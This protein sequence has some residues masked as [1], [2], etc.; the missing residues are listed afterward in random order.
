MR[1]LVLLL[2]FVSFILSSPAQAGEA[3]FSASSP[4]HRVAVLELYTSQ[5]CSSCPPAERWLSRLKKTG[6]SSEQ[7][8]PLAFHV[9]YWDYI[10][11]KDRFGSERYDNRQREIARFNRQKT[12]YTP[13]FVLGGSDYRTYNR[14]SSDVSHIV[15]MPSSID[16]KITA[17]KQGQTD[18]GVEVSADISKSKLKDVV[19]FLALYENNLKSHIG[20]GENEGELLHHDYVVRQ[21]YGPFLKN[22]K[23][24]ENHPSAAVHQ[25][26]LI[27]ESWKQNEMGLVAF[28]QNPQTGEIL[29]A[30]R[31]PLGGRI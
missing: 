27:D 26:V 23:Q 21:F 28:A 15:S 11:W 4:E 24:T 19:L 6:A 13:Q 3:V 29:Q 7:L 8:I 18:L 9:T 16:L 2:L 5:G 14:F 12:I 30:V 1:T 20:E 25:S 22:T 17:K 10:G 31:L